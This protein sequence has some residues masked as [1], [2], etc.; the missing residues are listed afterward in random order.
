MNDTIDHDRH[1]VTLGSLL[2]E[3]HANARW[4]GERYPATQALAD[5]VEG[6]LVFAKSKGQDVFNTYEKRLRTKPS[7]RDAAIEEL[8]VAH[9]LD[10]KHF[11]VMAWAPIGSGTREGEFVVRDR[12]GVDVFVEV[13]GPGWEGELSKN[14][15][16]SGRKDQPKYQ[17]TEAAYPKNT[18]KVAEAVEKAYPKFSRSTRNLLVI[19]DDLYIP[20]QF[21]SEFWAYT[22]LYDQDGKFIDHR[23]ENLG[24]VGFLTRQQ[25][26][27]RTGMK[28]FLNP[29][30]LSP[31]P[32]TL[33]R[34][35]RGRV[36]HPA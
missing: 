10:R 36:V 6:L 3:I 27:N 32:A 28:L 21:E 17:H 2:S 35:F 13:K 31:L 7:Q 4:K 34:T 20:L 16:R 22:A 15:L 29:H 19:A 18:T 9:L 33:V 26:S 23:C 12:G 24:G 14:Q 8:R 5:E 25:R 11:T 1:V 30:A